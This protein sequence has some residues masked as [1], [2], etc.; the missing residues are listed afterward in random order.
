MKIAFALFSYLLGSIPFGYV[1]F[2][3]SEKKDIRK[4]GSQSTGATNILRL[5]GWKPALLVLL[6]DVS[7]G[8]L[9][10][11]LVLQIFNDRRLALISALLAVLGHC[12]P[13]YI[14]FKGGKGLATTIGAYAGLAFKPLLLSLGLFLIVVIISRYVSLGSLLA[15]CS[16]PFFLFLF[17]G[18]KGLILLSLAL[19]ILIVF[20]HREN[21]RRLIRGQERRIGEK[22]RIE[23]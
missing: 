20:Q 5:K 11:F 12:F 2:R 17:K 15:A 22:I 18:E 6:L 23:N 1:L 8:L 16:F 3:F 21:I 10:V 19:L 7:K 4:Y 13:V 9:P 14:Q